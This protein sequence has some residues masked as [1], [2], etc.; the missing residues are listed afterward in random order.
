MVVFDL[1]KIDN[2]DIM[3]VKKIGA[4]VCMSPEETTTVP[5]TTGTIRCDLSVGICILIL[6]GKTMGRFVQ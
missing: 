1:V 2:S 3:K 5:T 4:D 6:N